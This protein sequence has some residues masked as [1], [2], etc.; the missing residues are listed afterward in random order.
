M[1]GVFEEKKQVKK[2]DCVRTLFPKLKAKD[3]KAREI[4]RILDKKPVRLFPN[5]SPQHLISYTNTL[6]K[7][8]K[9]MA[10]KLPNFDVTLFQYIRQ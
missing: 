4:I 8:S 6:L 3:Q 9:L 5:F 10:H 7:D 1:L 2:L